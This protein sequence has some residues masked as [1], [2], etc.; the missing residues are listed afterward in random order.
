MSPGLFLSIAAAVFSATA[1]I[2]AVLA[3]WGSRR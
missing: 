1:A 3:W 2:F